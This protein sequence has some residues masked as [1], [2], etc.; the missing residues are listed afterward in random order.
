MTT[1]QV[2]KSSGRFHL[3]QFLSAR[4]GYHYWSSRRFCG[5]DNK[6]IQII[7]ERE[8]SL[9]R[10]A[11]CRLTH[12]LLAACLLT[13]PALITSA[14]AAVTVLARG[15]AGAGNIIVDS[16]R[17]FWMNQNNGAVRSIDKLSSGTS[18][19]TTHYGG[20]GYPGGALVQDTSFLY[21]T[22]NGILGQNSCGAITHGVFKV[23]KT[24]SSAT[25]LDGANEFSLAISIDNHTLYYVSEFQTVPNSNGQCSVTLQKIAT[26]GGNSTP[27]I[28]LVV[29]STWAS[30]TTGDFSADSVYLHWSDD[31][32]N[33]ISHIPLAG[34]MVSTDVS[35]PTPGVL[36]TPTTGAAG[37]YLFWVEG[38]GSSSTL[39]RKSALGSIIGLFV[40]VPNFSNIVHNFVVVGSDVYCTTS[41]GTIVKVPIDGL[42]VGGVAPV[43]VNATDGNYPVGL[44]SDGTYLFWTAAG[45]GS[46]RRIAIPITTSA[47]TNVAAYSATLNGS[48][49]PGGLTTSVY[50]Q[51]GTTTSYGLT[52]AMQSQAGN[53]FRN[54]SANISSLMANHVYHF[55]V[56]ATNTGGTRYG[57]DRTFTTL[58]ATGPPVVT[59][60]PATLVASF[61]ALLNGSLDPHGLTTSVHFQ[62]G[63]TTSY[64]L[65][66]APQSHTGNT[67]LNISANIS[68]LLASHVYHFRIVATNSAGTRYGS[69]RTFTTLSATGAPVVTTKPA[70][71]VAIS[72][73]TLNGSLDPHG[74]TTTVYFQWGATTSYGH[75][76]AMQT[77]TGSAYRNITRNINGLSTNTTYHFRMVATNSAGTRFGVGR[78]FTTP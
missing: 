2:R 62:Y 17:V 77:Q 35:A 27:V 1:P 39:K 12:W 11:S 19:V 4:R 63:T 56:V 71:N 76:T 24:S 74:L 51:Y 15:Q 14:G 7:R 42:P 34:G 33:S 69:D 52:T 50:F 37:G 68:G 72:S 25:M 26:V 73:A 38:N 70:T 59:T 30:H 13:T 49:N 47:A 6:M 23:L 75:T 66:T 48:V 31:T 55:R 53:T 28:P 36:S 9:A 65:T 32:S 29:N 20:A 22:V 3:P 57:S 5:K 54:V 78:G 45:D 40:G 16:S 10:R 41:T 18:S 8:I 67:Y 44:T 21:F 61:S 43:I 60:N 46:I 64:G 58:S